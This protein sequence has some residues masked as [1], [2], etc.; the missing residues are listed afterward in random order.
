MLVRKLILLSFVWV[1]FFC[2]AQAGVVIESSA[3]YTFSKNSSLPSSPDNSSWGDEANALNVRS[4]IFDGQEA[5]ASNEVQML[6]GQNGSVAAASSILSGSSKS[7]S[8]VASGSRLSQ[9]FSASG[10]LSRRN[11]SEAVAD[12]ADGGSMSMPFNVIMP[13]DDFPGDPNDPGIIDPPD[14][15]IGEGCGLLLLSALA[16]ALAKRKR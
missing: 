11:A 3:K 2:S 5:V 13:K 7:L 12:V 8:R 14:T 1:G 6:S 15:P 16:Y 10:S 9:R 4:S